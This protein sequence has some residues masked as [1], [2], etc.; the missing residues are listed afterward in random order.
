MAI[1]SYDD[2]VERM[3]LVACSTSVELTA[4]ERSLLSI[5]FSNVV[6]S[7][8]ASWR[9]ISALEPKNGERLCVEAYRQKIE[10][11]LDELC[12]D[13]LTLLDKHVLPKSASAEDFVFFYKMKGDYYRYSAEF[14]LGDK[15]A[16]SA[17]HSLEAYKQAHDT[18][19]AELTPTHPVRLGLALNFSVFYFEILDAVD[20][21]C[22]M[23]KQAFDDAISELDTLSETS[24]RDSVLIM[25]LLR[26]NIMLWR[27]NEDN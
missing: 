20:L 5:A 8:R 13:V 11:E 6:G 27:S 1:C 16:E 3:K 22:G 19:V 14:Q 2:M 10:R 4:E 17:K 12:S 25:Q 15:R 24:Y 26:D 18:A 23:S 21:A 9:V 7:R